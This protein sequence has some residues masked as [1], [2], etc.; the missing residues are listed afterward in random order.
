M[1]LQFPLLSAGL[2]LSVIICIGYKWGISPVLARHNRMK[3]EELANFLYDE[4]YGKQDQEKAM[5]Q[6]SS[7]ET[8]DDT[9]K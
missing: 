8:K 9:A 5:F 7:T 4:K 3:Q 6:F 2:A 1:A